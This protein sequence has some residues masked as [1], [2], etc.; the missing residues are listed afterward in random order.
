[1]M[2]M[3]RGRFP[4]AL[5]VMLAL[6]APCL[7]QWEIPAREGNAGSAVRVGFLAQL[8]AEALDTSDG[9]EVAKDLFLRRLR[10]MAGGKIND[11]LSFFLETDSPN[12][13]KGGRYG[14]KGAS[15]IFLQDIFVSFAATDEL[16]IETGMLLPHLSYNHNQSATSLLPGEYGPFSFTESGPIDARVGRDYGVQARGYLGENHF[17]YRIGVY[18]G[19][20][21][22]DSTHPLRVTA[23]VQWSALD[24]LRGMFYPGPTLGKKHLLVIGASYDTQDDYHAH[25]ASLFYDHPLAKRGAVSF[26]AEYIF[27]DG[28]QFLKTLPEHTTWLFEGSWYFA[29]K[30]IGPYFEYAMR[31]NA[32]AGIADEERSLIGVCWW[33]KGQRLNLRA[34]L[35]RLER[36]GFPSR[37]QIMIQLQVMTY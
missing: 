32:D 20:R 36:D 33:I 34:A 8:R 17:E 18:Q 7:A 2:K 19:Y 37:D 1:M 12:L 16:Y 11:R 5:L 27:R 3:I 30:R 10:L 21:G 26:L 31:D 25:S 24:T 22:E 15:D 14:K 9:P 29:S 6:S 35:R 23:R 13:G 28:N 4:V